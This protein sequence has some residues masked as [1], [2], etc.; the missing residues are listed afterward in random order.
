MSKTLGDITSELT[1][2]VLAPAKA[3]AELLLNDA[4]AEAGKIVAAAEVEAQKIR[5][6]AKRDVDNLKKQMDIDLETASRNFLMMVEERLEKIV[7]EPVVEE[8]VKPLLEDAKF[9]EQMILELL[10]AY[11]QR[12]G[13]EHHIEILLPQVKKAELENWFVEKCRQKIGRPI[14]VQFTDKISFGFKIGVAGEGSH[15]NFSEGLVEVFSEFCS[16]RFRKYF[17]PRKES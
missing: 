7:V 9:L 3:E 13:K 15:V 6:E 4:Q 2:K 5:A 17:L 11:V 14:E 8:T 1:Q 16:P 10:A 12:G